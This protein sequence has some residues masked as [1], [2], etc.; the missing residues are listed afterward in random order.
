M[1]FTLESNFVVSPRTGKVYFYTEHEIAARKKYLDDYKVKEAQHERLWLTLVDNSV[2]YHMQPWECA[3]HDD[4]SEN[5][6][7]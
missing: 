7:P 5:S 2:D 3:D 1:N 4:Y 6:F